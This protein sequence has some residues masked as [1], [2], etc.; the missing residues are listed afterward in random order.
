MSGGLVASL[1]APL[2]QR[3]DFSEVLTGSWTALS[4]SELSRRPVYLD[5]EGATALGELFDLTGD[6]NGRIRFTGNLELADRLGA[7]MIEGNVVVEGDV[8][9][10]AGLSLAGGSLLIDGDA[11]RRAGAA[12]SGFKR[13]MT[14]GELVVR[15]SAGPEAGSSMRRGLVAIVGRAG[16]RTGLGMIAGTIVT[17]GPVGADSGLWSKRG[18]L[19]ALGPIDLPPTYAYACTYKPVHLKLLLIRLRVTYDLPVKP[20]HLNGFYRRYSGDLA[21]LGKGEILTWSLR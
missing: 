17:F 10:E 14:G 11:G 1:R 8:G 4:G 15:G 16:D 18:S 12:P 7:G 6:S 3:A 19:V 21:E 2:R 13:G 20:K 9:H 5:G